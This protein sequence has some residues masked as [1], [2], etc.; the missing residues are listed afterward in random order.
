M[1]NVDEDDWYEEFDTG[2]DTN[3]DDYDATDRDGDALPATSRRDA[4]AAHSTAA[5]TSRSNKTL[6]FVFLSVSSPLL[7]SAA[8]VSSAASMCASASRCNVASRHDYVTGN[9]AKHTNRLSAAL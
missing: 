6:S 3:F 7:L 5:Q 8:W 2:S 9:F 4:D 1:T